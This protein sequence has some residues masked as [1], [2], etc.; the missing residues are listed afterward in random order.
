MKD[1]KTVWWYIAK[2]IK[3]YHSGLIE[4]GFTEDQ[5]M[6]LAA[7]LSSKLLDDSL[8]TMAKP[9]NMTGDMKKVIDDFIKKMDKKE[10]T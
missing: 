6:L 1:D 10:G 2:A 4:H 8:R 3:G 9:L 5:A 7:A